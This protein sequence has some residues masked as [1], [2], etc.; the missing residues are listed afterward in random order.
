MSLI[1]SNWPNSVKL[2]VVGL[3]VF[4]AI[5]LVV[6]VVILAMPPTA[7]TV[8]TAAPPEPPLTTTPP[9]PARPERPTSSAPQISRNDMIDLQ[10]VGCDLLGDGLTKELL[11]QCAEKAS[12][13]ATDPASVE[14]SRAVLRAH[15][16]PLI[17]PPT[18]ADGPLFD[19]LVPS[20]NQAQCSVWGS[21]WAKD[22][23]DELRS[24]GFRKVRCANGK[25]WVL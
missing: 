22:S 11:A 7:V 1:P 13:Y 4:T 2:A 18:K 16:A 3:G 10:Y 8:A 9:P 19:V 15:M 21:M 14:H 25:E 24:I 6:E 12:H 17:Q 23:A 5:V 20:P